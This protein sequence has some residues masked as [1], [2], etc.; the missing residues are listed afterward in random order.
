MTFSCVFHQTA[1]KSLRDRHPLGPKIAFASP[2][3]PFFTFFTRVR[4]ICFKM[5]SQIYDLV[6]NNP[7][8]DPKVVP[9]ELG[10]LG[11]PAERAGPAWLARAGQPGRP[12]PPSSP[13][14]ALQGGG[15]GRAKE[16]S[17][18]QENPAPPLLSPQVGYFVLP[19][20]PLWNGSCFLEKLIK[21]MGKCHK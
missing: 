8:S 12:V 9:D 5:T 15:E 17:S 16:G 4:R 14:A 20:N 7:L 11:R 13:W 10:R 3:S 2:K 21:R 19:G 6:S 18:A 1:L